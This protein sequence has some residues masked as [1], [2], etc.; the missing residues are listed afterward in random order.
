MLLDR[1]EAAL[2]RTD[3]DDPRVLAGATRVVSIVKL[4]SEAPVGYLLRT[5]M[6]DGAAGPQITRP[7]PA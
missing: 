7:L 5:R 6:R 4:L 3:I 2:A 1:N